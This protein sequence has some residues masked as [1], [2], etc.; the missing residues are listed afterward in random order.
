[1]TNT[2]KLIILAFFLLNFMCKL[3]AQTLP[4]QTDPDEIIFCGAT[5]RSAESLA[6]LLPHSPYACSS[7]I[8]PGVS[9]AIYYEMW[10]F[11]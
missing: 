4:Q 6:S 2:T 7:E 8:P 3:N 1:M 9:N 11:Y 10:T 5:H